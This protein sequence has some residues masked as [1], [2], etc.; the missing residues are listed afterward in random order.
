MTRLKRFSL[1]LGII[2]AMYSSLQ[3]D[4]I[5]QWID[6]Y[7]MICTNTETGQVKYIYFN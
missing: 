3:A 4:E 1:M 7:T 6:Q 2:M 5:C